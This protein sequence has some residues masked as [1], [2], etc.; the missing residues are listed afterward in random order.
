METLN[1]RSIS[2]EDCAGWGFDKHKNFGE[3]CESWGF[4]KQKNAN[5]VSAASV[6][7]RDIRKRGIISRN[8]S[9]VSVLLRAT[10]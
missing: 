5:V 8:I 4:D 3:D 10:L 6:G 1:M 7:S 2:E 9:K